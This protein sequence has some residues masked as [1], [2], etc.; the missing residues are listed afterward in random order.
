MAVTPYLTGPLREDFDRWLDAAV[1]RFAP[2]AAGTE[3]PAGGREPPLRFREVRKGVQALS[4][5]YVEGRE[6]KDL[7]AR[8][9][10]GRG[11]RGAL[12]TYYAPLHFLATHHALAALGPARL[13]APARVLDL[14][15]G[16]GA[17]GA[18]A[19]RAF[20]EP[21]PR[22]MGVDRS[23]FALDEARRT[24]SAFGLRGQAR[25][26]R[27]PRGLPAERARDLVVLGWCVN[28][29]SED[30]RAPLL[31]ALCARLRGGT[32]LLLLEPLSG[33]VSPW[34][35]A[36]REALAPLGVEPGTL[37]VPI[38]RPAWVARLD[39]ASA[40]RHDTLGAR[41]LAGPLD[42]AGDCAPPP[43]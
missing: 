13:G 4:H 30:E 26:A 42:P 37:R 12:A 34:W 27:L 11:K 2:G 18:A 22:A 19:A 41:W 14:G 32:R 35:K 7:S 25:R 5:L 10:A 31:E 21:P 20:A 28:E 6:G 1:A 23:G 8:A 33:R 15:C 3:A 24:W 40:L 43:A 39:R 9:V 16:T 29:L 36:W 38:A 17:A